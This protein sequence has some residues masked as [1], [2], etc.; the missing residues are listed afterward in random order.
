MRATQDLLKQENEMLTECIDNL[1]EKMI[2]WKVNLRV[3]TYCYLVTM[4]RMGKKLG[5]NV[6]TRLL[7]S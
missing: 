5:K 2:T 6:K 3:K 4:S 1:D 7:K